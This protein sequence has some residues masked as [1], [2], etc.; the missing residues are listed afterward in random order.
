MVV[1]DPVADRDD[2]LHEYGIGILPELSND[3]FQAVVLAVKHREIMALGPIGSRACSPPVADL[4]HHR[5]APARRKR[6]RD[7]RQ[8]LTQVCRRPLLDEG[9]QTYAMIKDAI[10]GGR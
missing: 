7:L 6:R 8:G 9:R 10:L 4:R 3:R 2:A 5:R 1:Y